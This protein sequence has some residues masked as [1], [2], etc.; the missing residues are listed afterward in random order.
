MSAGRHG[1]TPRPHVLAKDPRLRRQEAQQADALAARQFDHGGRGRAVDGAR[2]IA[3]DQLRVEL[4]EPLPERLEPDVGLVVAEARELYAHGVEHL[5][6]AAAAVQRRQHRRR[7]EVAR[8]R[9]DDP[10]L[11]LRLDAVDERAQLRQ[12][13]EVVDVVHGYERER[14]RSCGGEAA[15]APPAHSDA[16]ARD[17]CSRGDE[18]R[19]AAPQKGG[20]HHCLAITPASCETQPVGPEICSSAL[21]NLATW[22]ELPQSI[23]ATQNRSL[24]IRCEHY[25][26][27]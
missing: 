14:V 24:S 16:C 25:L 1:Q 6:H 3:V 20:E 9:R 26:A 18:A 8:E 5:D 11:A 15:W 4:R 13:L 7:Q 17:A 10:T 12:V 2:D 21:A 19:A 23:N 27:Q 22:L